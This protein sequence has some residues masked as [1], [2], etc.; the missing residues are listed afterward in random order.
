MYAGVLPATYLRGS[1]DTVHFPVWFRVA[2]TRKTND[3]R[4]IE[5]NTHCSLKT[6]SIDRNEFNLDYLPLFD[7]LLCEYLSR[8]DMAACFDLLNHYD[9]NSDDVQT[10]LSISSYEKRLSPRKLVW[11]SDVEA[12]LKTKLSNER[13]R[14]PFQPIDVN[15]LKHDDDATKNAG[16]IRP[17]VQRKRR[18]VAK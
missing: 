5:L 1:L 8:K 18:R 9:F 3:R 7:H 2:Q 10:I 15:T 17:I 4:A 16:E 14:A 6:T 11:N 13:R 12:L